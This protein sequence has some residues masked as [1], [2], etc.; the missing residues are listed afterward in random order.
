MINSEFKFEFCGNSEEQITF[1]SLEVNILA[2]VAKPKFQNF[3]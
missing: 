2:L 1:N 3:K